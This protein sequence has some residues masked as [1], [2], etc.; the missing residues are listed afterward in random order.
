MSLTLLA[1]YACHFVGTTLV[2]RPG[3]ENY[4]AFLKLIGPIG[5]LFLCYFKEGANTDEIYGFL[6][7]IN[8]DLVFMSQGIIDSVFIKEIEKGYTIFSNS[9]L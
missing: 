2:M 7:M 8:F 1:I 4:A 5:S 3:M 6:A 9:S